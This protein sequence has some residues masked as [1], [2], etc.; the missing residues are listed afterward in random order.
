MLGFTAAEVRGILETYRDHGVFDQDMDE[1]IA[2]M[3]EW[4]NGYRFATATGN[5]LYNTDM[6][7]YYLKASIPNEAPPDD[8]IDTNVR[9]ASTTA[10]CATCSPSTGSWGCRSIIDAAPFLALLMVPIGERIVASRPL[11]V[12]CGALLMW[13]DSTTGRI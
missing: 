10:N 8:L 3:D 4:Y 13:S 9:T 2:V 11:R 6:V 5:H 12:V 1:A 7:L